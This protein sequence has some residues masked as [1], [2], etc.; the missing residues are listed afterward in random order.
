MSINSSAGKQVFHNTVI[1]ASLSIFTFNDNLNNSNN[2]N[3]KSNISEFMLR[4]YFKK[5][6]AVIFI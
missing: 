4:N 1:F 5:R 3:G 6:E 2:R